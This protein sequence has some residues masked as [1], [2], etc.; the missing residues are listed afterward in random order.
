MPTR[1]K[2]LATTAL[3]PLVAATNSVAAQDATPPAAQDPVE[4]LRDVAYGEAGGET[5]LVDVNLPPRRDTP[6]PAVILIHGGAWTTG[7]GSRF[8]LL[9]FAHDLA[10]EGY[11]V[12]NAEYRL[13]GGMPG[14]NTPG[15]NVWPAQLDD[16][17]RAVRWIRA[18]AATYGVDPDR[19]GSYG[20]SA[21]GHLAAMLGVRDTR[22]NSDA[23][24][25]GY[26]SRV[27]CVCDFAG[28]TDQLI[29]DPDPNWDDLLAVFLGGTPDEVP[30]A[31]R[32][33]S[34]V[35]W[36]DE[37]S[38][39]HLIIHGLIDDIQPIAH[40]RVMV[41]ALQA[42]GVEVVAAELAWVTHFDGNTWSVVSPLLL[43]FLER[44]LHP[45]R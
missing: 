18:N 6:R 12:F 19:I 35:N 34:P 31:Y 28:S 27:T 20:T 32:D 3:V 4:V 14:S 41:A 40:S 16:L 5:L 43:G 30:D 24:L 33:S 13:M 42:A 45:E 7:L 1:R 11:V 38:A 25:A 26:S 8:D 15:L 2:L 21:G 36:V 23:D 17:Q 39:P 22:D 44:H 10:A 29:P 37:Q 9:R